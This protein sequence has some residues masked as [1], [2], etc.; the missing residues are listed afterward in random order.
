MQWR[1]TAPEQGT[2]ITYAVVAEDM[3]FDGA[4]NCRSIE[5]VSRKRSLSS[6]W[7]QASEGLRT[8]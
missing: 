8:F 2:V 5:K 7:R 6:R 1:G 3:A 4:R